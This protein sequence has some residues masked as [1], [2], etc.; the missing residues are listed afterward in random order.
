MKQRDLGELI[1]LAAIWGGSFLFMRIG[2]PEFGVAPLVGLRVIGATLVL[3]PLVAMRGAWPALRQHWKPIFIVGLTNSAFPFMLFTYAALSISAGLSSIFNAAAPLFGAL[4]A[5][6]WLKDKLNTTRVLGLVIG[7]A[8]VF[9]L[10]WSKATLKA[11]GA[12]AA[13]AIGACLLATV[14]YGFSANFTKRYLTGVAPIAVAGGSQLSAAL[15]LVVPTVV[16]WPA[17][18]P[19]FA[20]WVNVVALAV[21]C[22]GAAYIMYFRLIAHIG[23]ANAITVTFLVPAFAVVWGAIFLHETLTVQMVVGCAVILAGTS[24]ATGLFPRA[25]TSVAAAVRRL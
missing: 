24:L 3:M 1:L 21:V 6:L 17:S 11:D 20:G 22:T 10:A 23:P 25:G 19:S 14:S 15:A 7:F 18:S 13:L 2:A 12:G 16:L 8:G 4:F 5:W 9:W